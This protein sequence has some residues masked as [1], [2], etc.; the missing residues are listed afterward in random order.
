MLTGIDL[1]Y[2]TINP[3]NN[4]DF[5]QRVLV[6]AEKLE[7]QGKITAR[8]HQKV[9]QKVHQKLKIRYSGLSVRIH[10]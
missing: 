3:H 4:D 8:D 5:L 1:Q 2:P 7:H 6:E 10:L 9:H